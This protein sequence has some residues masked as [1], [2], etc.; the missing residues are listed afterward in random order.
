MHKYSRKLKASNVN[1]NTP[2]HYTRFTLQILVQPLQ[3]VHDEE[4]KLSIYSI[5]ERWKFLLTDREK[6]HTHDGHQYC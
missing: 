6:K 4:I 2:C 5:I 1:H 3:I